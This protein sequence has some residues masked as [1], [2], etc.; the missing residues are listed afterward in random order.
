MLVDVIKNGLNGSASFVEAGACYALIKSSN[1]SFRVASSEC[2]QK[3]AALPQNYI[4]ET[5]PEEIPHP[6]GG[7]VYEHRTA[8]VN[9]EGAI[10]AAKEEL[11]HRVGSL[12]ESNNHIDRG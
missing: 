11:L 1:V 9:M 2:L 5:T 7:Y 6:G 10:G 4:H 12:S 3:I 8:S